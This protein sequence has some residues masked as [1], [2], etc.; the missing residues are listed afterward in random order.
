MPFNYFE[1]WYSL[2]EIGYIIKQI[3]ET[4]WYR[5]EFEDLVKRESEMK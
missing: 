4:S 1:F 2:F 3:L 5:A